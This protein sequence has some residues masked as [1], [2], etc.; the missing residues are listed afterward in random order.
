MPVI[1]FRVEDDVAIGAHRT[2]VGPRLCPRSR[3]AAR[4]SQPSGYESDRPCSSEVNVSGEGRRSGRAPGVDDG[5]GPGP[6]RANGGWR[7]GGPAPARSLFRG[8]LPVAD[9]DHGDH[10]HGGSRPRRRCASGLNLDGANR[11]RSGRIWVVSMVARGRQWRTR[12]GARSG[13]SAGVVVGDAD[14]R[15][16]RWQSCRPLLSRAVLG[17]AFVGPASARRGAAIDRVAQA[18]GLGGPDGNVE[19]G[20]HLAGE[21]PM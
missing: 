3:F 6:V 17:R 20:G 13:G 9:D 8:E 12:S 16:S 15:G 10:G 11:P 21:R 1:A 4:T 7:S 19:G 14:V 2:A 18:C 5:V